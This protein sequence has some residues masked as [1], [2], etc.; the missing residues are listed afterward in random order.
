MKSAPNLVMLKQTIHIH[1]IMMITMM[2][3]L[4]N[5]V[6]KLALTSHAANNL[7]LFAN[8]GRFCLDILRRSSLRRRGKIWY[9][10]RMKHEIL[11]IDVESVKNRMVAYNTA[12]ALGRKI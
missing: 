7:P 2:I 1:M 5:S 11:P 8:S 4:I 10:V 3:G 12:T 9:T 6:N